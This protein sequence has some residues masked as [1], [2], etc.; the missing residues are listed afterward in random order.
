LFSPRLFLLVVVTAAPAA[1]PPSRHAIDAAMADLAEVTGFRI[2]APLAFESITREQVKT[3][4]NDKM[5][6]AVKPEEIRAEELTLKMFGFVP[7]DFDLKKATLELLTEQTAAFYDFHEKKLFIT[8]WAA[9]KMV[10]EALV[11]ELAH[12]LAD[13]NFNLE[14]YTRKVEDDSEK[15]LARQAVVEGQAQWLTRAVLLKRGMTPESNE[16]G[17]AAKPDDESPIF[18][19]APLYFQA[20]LMFPYDVGESFQQAVFEKFGKEGFTRVFQHP[21]VSAQQV[22]HPERYFSGQKPLDVD[23]PPV[24]GMKRLVEGPVGEL[25][26]AILLQQY[27]GKDAAR[28]LSPHWRGG[29]F[30]VYEKKK[31]KLDVLV[32]RSVWSDDASAQ[33]FYEAYEQILRGKWKK[34]DIFARS[35][36]RIDGQG[37]D[38]YFCVDVSATVVT[39]REGLAAECEK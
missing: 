8:D 17:A 24:K 9:D 33:K 28:D 5:K 37:D 3:F 31:Q 21:P 16:T 2:K 38:G 32:Y 4:L 25:D 15:S 18:D 10:E 11:H 36:N 30:R 14:R 22:L 23:V 6:S 7:Q 39:S 27:V 1:E 12:A 29:Y 19:K 13:Q 34:I 35:D 20:T 26:H